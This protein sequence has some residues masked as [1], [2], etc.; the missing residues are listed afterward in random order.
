MKTSQLSSVLVLAALLGAC[1]SPSS[2]PNARS[3]SQPALDQ[4]AT[5]ARAGQ[6][7]A[8]LA[9]IETEMPRANDPTTRAR[10]ELLRGRS[11][12]ADGRL[13]SASLAFGRAF[14]ALPSETG[15]LAREV[16]TAWGDADA[17]LLRWR[18]AASHY[19]LALDAGVPSPRV[20]DDLMYSAYVAAREAGDGGGAARWKSKIRLFS[21][22]RLAAVE[23]RLLPK[24]R[25]STTP[26]PTA[27]PTL[28]RGVIPDDPSLILPG[29]KRRAAWGAASIR[30]NSDKMLPVTHVTVH[31]TAMLSSST[32]PAAVGSEIRL[33][34]SNHQG[35]GWADIGYHVLIDAGG[36]VWE[37]RPLKLQGAHEGA[38]L[39]RGAVGVCLLGNFEEQP[40]PA[41]QEAALVRVLD[42]LRQQFLLDG[43]D[44]RTH[45]EV[46]SDPTDC[47]GR[48]LQAA[49][50]RYRRAASA[51]SVAR[52]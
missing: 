7:E 18:D 23:T 41:A 1:V 15:D 42:A 52:Q 51:T 46:R 31:H 45:R 50:D 34:Q 33:I 24:A 14:D 43:S 40:L 12:Q 4:I 25:R 5:L 47:P 16:L 17:A 38:G 37:G 3:R 36:T 13:R 2:A 44:I 26:P 27:A 39:N 29:I 8:A 10:L 28:A 11:L 32:W 48:A 6:H 19:S 21:A 49:V 22:S 35:Q 30:A 20:R 9:R